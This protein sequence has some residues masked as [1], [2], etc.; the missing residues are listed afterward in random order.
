MRSLASPKNAVETNRAF[1]DA[2]EAWLLRSR[3]PQ[4]DTVVLE[5]VQRWQEHQASGTPEGGILSETGAVLVPSPPRTMWLRRLRGE[6]KIATWLLPSDRPILIG[7][8]GKRISPLDI[9]LWPDMSISRRHAIVWFDGETWRIEDLRSK[10][11]TF[12]AKTD[13]RGQRA[14]QLQ[15]GMILRFGCTVLT[16]AVGAAAH[17]GMVEAGVDDR[18]ASGLDTGQTS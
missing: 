2:A 9:D 8:S 12:I 14:V 10:N 5:A 11:G 13:L 6:Q 15:P 7:R 17:N 18:A 3:N 16:L 1:E 4:A